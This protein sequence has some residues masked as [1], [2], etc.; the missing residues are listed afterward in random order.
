MSPAS[1][2]TAP[3][4]V[5]CGSLPPVFRSPSVREPEQ[6]DAAFEDAA[7]VGHL[8]EQAVKLVPLG[9]VEACEESFFDLAGGPFGCGQP[10]PALLRDFDDMPSAILGIA[11]AGDQALRLEVVEQPHELARVDSDRVDQSL[12]TR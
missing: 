5:A 9:L 1:Y 8:R 7:R 10:S 4:R 11:A 2:L 6:L 12:L 3:P